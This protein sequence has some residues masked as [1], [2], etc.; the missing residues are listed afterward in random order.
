MYVTA[1]SLHN[2][3]AGSVSRCLMCALYVQ[4]EFV[5]DKPRFNCR[6]FQE[7]LPLQV[8]VFIIKPQSAQPENLGVVLFTNIQAPNQIFHRTF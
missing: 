2:I 8:P 4:C 3:D 1:A 7:L 5:Y 6:R